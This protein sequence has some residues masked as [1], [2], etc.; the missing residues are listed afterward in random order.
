MKALPI[1][2]ASVLALST[3]A[4][5]WMGLESDK[6]QTSYA[7]PGQG[8]PP[9]TASTA[10][11]Q[12]LSPQMAR[13]VQARL[14]QNGYMPGRVDG[15]WGDQSRMAL[16][17]FQRDRNLPQTGM[18]D[19][20]TLAALG[21]ASP[22]SSVAHSRPRGPAPQS[23]AMVRDVQER[24]KEKGY[25]VG[26]ID[27]IWG[28]QT[29]QALSAFQKDQQLSQVGPLDE[30]TMVALGVEA[31]S[32]QQTGQLPAEEDEAAPP[33]QTGEVP[34]SEPA[35]AEPEPQRSPNEPG[36]PMEQR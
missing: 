12:E 35:P 2:A 29:Q 32:N 7:P 5:Q 14:N 26:A 1:V 31:E 10:S 22:A 9:S 15:V 21:V 3:A 36:Q 24:L 20:E 11:T 16:S 4:C 17:N 8:G 27:G 30:Q 23:S 6:S 34:Q 19:T 25:R 33:E 18:I 13:D 28:P